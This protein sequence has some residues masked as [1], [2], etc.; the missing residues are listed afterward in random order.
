M[1]QLPITGVRAGSRPYG[2]RARE[3]LTPAAAV[4]PPSVPAS[5][6]VI[7]PAASLSAKLLVPPGRSRHLVGG[8]VGGNSVGAEAF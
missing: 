1:R 3:P 2:N 7:V 6:P 5:L 8:D 4:V